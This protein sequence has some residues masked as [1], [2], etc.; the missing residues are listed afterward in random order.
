MRGMFRA[1]ACLLLPA[2]SVALAAAEEAPYPPSPVV[3]S[4]AFAPTSEIVIRGH[5]DNW[6]ITWAD[7]DA[8]YTFYCDGRGFG[9][10]REKEPSTAPARITGGPG[11][12]AGEDVESPTGT[13]Y[14]GGSSGAKASGL[15]AAD[16]VL[17]VWLRNVGNSKLGWSRDH[18]RTWEYGFTFTE[19]FGYPTFLN[20]GKDC[21]GARD[22]YV[23]VYSQ[24]GDTAYE[25]YDGV[26]LARVPRS[27][28]RERDAYEFFQAR[29][30]QGRPVW[31]RDTAG[32]GHV[33]AFPKHCQRL[34]VVFN[35]ALQ[36]YFMAIGYNHL[37]GWGLYDAPEPWGP[38]TTCFHTEK[39]DIGESFSYR[40]PSK[41]I[42]GDGRTMHFVLSA[43]HGDGKYYAFAV[44]K[45][46]LEPAR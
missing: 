33:F 1:L 37:G 42:A 41:W 43:W 20:F 6:P 10:K 27:K 5:G 19:S 35:P 29:D 32:R 16:G 31:T 21:A 45:M 12:F 17:Y 3:K 30:A 4:V 9:P 22:E 26:V 40:M 25:I 8:L 44:R 7:D 38:W 46:T 2:M 23:Y 24:D 28:I 14:G 36:R 39:W 15:L 13:S 11:E 18:G 34:D